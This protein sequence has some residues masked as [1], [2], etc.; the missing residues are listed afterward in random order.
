VVKI[1]LAIVLCIFLVWGLTRLADKGEDEDQWISQSNGR[2]G[3]T[4]V[5]FFLVEEEGDG[6]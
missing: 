6:G 2:K 1:T 4:E 5:K 3:Q